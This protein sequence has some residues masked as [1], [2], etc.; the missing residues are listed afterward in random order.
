[1]LKSKVNLN[2]SPY[3][4]K[5]YVVPLLSR[6][7]K[8]SMFKFKDLKGMNIDFAS[9]ILNLKVVVPTYVLEFLS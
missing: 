9:W 8:N 5:N 2:L 1:M 7:T 3:L 6:S 4:Q